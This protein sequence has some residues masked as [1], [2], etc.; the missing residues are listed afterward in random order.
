MNK[1]L[2]ALTLFNVKHNGA[3]QFSQKLIVISFALICHE[4]TLNAPMWR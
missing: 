3:F 1:I 2:A 4:I